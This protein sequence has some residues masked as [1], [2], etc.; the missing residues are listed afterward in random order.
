MQH[1]RSLS[2][3]FLEIKGC[4]QPGLTIALKRSG[5]CESKLSLNLET[6]DKI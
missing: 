6:V 4:S 3:S 1:E 5:K 2:Q